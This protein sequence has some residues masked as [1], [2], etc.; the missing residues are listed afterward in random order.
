[1][2]YILRE[3]AATMHTLEP[4][5]L[6]PHPLPDHHYSHSWPCD[7]RI[8]HE[9]SSLLSSDSAL[10][11]HQGIT[12]LSPFRI[13]HLATGLQHSVSATGQVRQ[14]RPKPAG[15]SGLSQ[16]TEGSPASRPNGMQAPQMPRQVLFN[17]PPL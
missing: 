14:D 15:T 10:T 2:A 12:P 7:R 1:M 6:S 5:A 8:G 3:R 17:V 13:Q 4:R 9:T 16:H 11:Q